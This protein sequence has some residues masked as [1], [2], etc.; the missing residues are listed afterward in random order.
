MQ[1]MDPSRLC[2]RQTRFLLYYISG[3]LFYY[4]FMTCP[5]TINCFIL[6][7]VKPHNKENSVIKEKHIMVSG[8]FHTSWEPEQAEKHSS[9]W[10]QLGQQDGQL[11]KFCF[12]DSLSS[13]SGRWLKLHIPWGLGA[14]PGCMYLPPLLHGSSSLVGN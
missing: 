6:K 10:A 3:P 11:Q 2:A 7:K 9:S 12:W 4:L 5:E 1:G 8:R 14:F 13:R